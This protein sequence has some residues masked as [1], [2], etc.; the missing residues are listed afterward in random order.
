MWKNEG[1]SRYKK[2]A[3]KL[4]LFFASFLCL[5]GMNCLG[6]VNHAKMRK[7]ITVVIDAGHGG[8]DPGK[9]SKDGVKEKD[10]NLQIAK[11]LKAELQARGVRV[12]LTRDEDT[13]LALPGARNKKSSDLQKRMELI[14]TS[15]ADYMISIHQ[16]SYPSSAVSGPQVFYNGEMEDS[17]A[18]AEAIQEDLIENLKPSKKRSAKEGN[19]YYILKKCNCTGVIIEC[20]FLSSP[21]ECEKL[22]NE[23]Y[24][25]LL[26]RTVAVSI[27]ETAP[28]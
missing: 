14:T 2:D 13:C 12:I 16:N 27:C 26:A 8:D 25:Q 15:Q 20:G 24:Q 11:R 6:Y 10:I 7:E 1:E 3:K 5:M 9:V 19:D 21:E 18:L 22:Q 23:Q 28:R 17:K 4:V